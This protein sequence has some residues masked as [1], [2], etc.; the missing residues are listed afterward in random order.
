[1]KTEDVIQLTASAIGIEPGKLSA[2]SQAADFE[3]WDSMGVLSLLAMFDRHG[4]NF[5]TGKIESLQSVRGI[6][7]AVRDTGKLE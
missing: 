1:M 5:D 3:G 2:D 6:L 4:I 7:Q